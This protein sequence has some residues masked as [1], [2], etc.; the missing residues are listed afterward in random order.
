MYAAKRRHFKGEKMSELIR[1]IEQNI[2]LTNEQNIARTQPGREYLS[3]CWGVE[4]LTYSKG[5]VDASQ[6]TTLTRYLLDCYKPATE[7]EARTIAT[8]HTPRSKAEVYQAVRL[9][10]QE[11]EVM[12]TSMVIRANQVLV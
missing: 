12:Q 5:R 7:Q 10:N 9:T 4:R 8:K 6:G 2:F 1:G 3:V 11:A